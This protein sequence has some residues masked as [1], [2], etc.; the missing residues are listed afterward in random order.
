YGSVLDNIKDALKNDIKEVRISNRLT[1]SAV[2]LVSDE[3]DISPQME[4]I[5][6][7]MNQEIPKSKRI[8]ELNPNHPILDVM[9]SIFENDKKDAKLT[10]YA[11]LLYDQAVLAEGTPLKDPV[12]FAQRMA[13]LMVFEGQTKVAKK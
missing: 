13:D 3:N 11:E 4:K 9:R 8:L 2:C 6:K 5:F 10:E 12:K 1:S 7:S